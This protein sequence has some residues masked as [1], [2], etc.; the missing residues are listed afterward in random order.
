MCKRLNYFRCADGLLNS[1]ASRGF[2]ATAELPVFIVTVATSQ[3][4]ISTAV[5]RQG[6]IQG[7][8]D[9]TESMVTTRSPFFGYNMAYCVE[10]RGEHLL[11]CLNYIQ[12]VG[13]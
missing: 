2:S 1:R 5:L 8:S 7:D 12:S 9:V 11:C 10:L 6:Y 13:L 4:M 3:A